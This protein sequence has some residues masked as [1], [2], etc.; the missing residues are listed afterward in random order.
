MAKLKMATSKSH[1]EDTDIG[2]IKKI[3]WIGLA[4]VVPT[5]QMPL[6]ILVMARRQKM[7]GPGPSPKEK[8][9]TVAPLAAST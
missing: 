1:N 4:G 9:M 8:D 6:V 7:W 5:T 3:T 2:E